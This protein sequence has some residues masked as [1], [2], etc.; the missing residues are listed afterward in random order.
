MTI[1][2]SS[3]KFLLM[4]SLTWTGTNEKVS[5]AHIY[6]TRVSNWIFF[7]LQLCQPDTL[8][9]LFGQLSQGFL[10]P[11]AMLHENQR[12]TNSSGTSCSALWTDHN[13]IKHSRTQVTQRYQAEEEDVESHDQWRKRNRSK[14]N[15][16]P[17]KHSFSFHSGAVSFNI[18]QKLHQWTWP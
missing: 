10:Q 4:S 7:H 9:V 5:L 1:L 18:L 15:V 6:E 3:F 2:E 12:R 13:E 14:R 17:L 11:D 8:C 16:S